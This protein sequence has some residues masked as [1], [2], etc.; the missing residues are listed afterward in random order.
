MAEYFRQKAL[1]EAEMDSSST[2]ARIL[3]AAEGLFANQGY[4]GTTT[5]EISDEADVN[6]ALIHYH[7]GSK[8]EL[9]NAVHAGIVDRGLE[10]IQS[11]IAE[12][13]R[14]DTVDDL[15][16]FIKKIFDWHIANPNPAKLWVMPGPERVS[17]Q[18]RREGMVEAFAAYVDNC[19]PLDF[20]P[21]NTGVAALLLMGAFR[22][23][24]IFKPEQI[25]FYA[26]EA[27]K[28]M[29]EEFKDQ[30]VET[31]TFLI[32]RFGKMA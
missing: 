32:A 12:Y 21:G 8:E 6:I 30:V 19:T 4:K 29:T 7:W 15:R 28:N 22:I 5:Q 11:I 10:L 13:P 2:K 1:D 20:G 9:W 14:V 25:A 3:N 31:L 23:F 26:G 18:E 27:G 24:F 16:G 17:D